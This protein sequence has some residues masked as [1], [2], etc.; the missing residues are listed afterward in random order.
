MRKVFPVTAVV[1]AGALTLSGCTAASAPSPS[2]SAAKPKMLTQLPAATSELDNVS[3]AYYAVLPTLDP[4]HSQSREA[5]LIIGNLCDTVL[6]AAPD[7]SVG[8]NLTKLKQVDDTHYVLT[9]VDG[10]KFWDGKPV[11]ASDVVYSLS[12]NLDPAVG[13]DFAPYFANV[14]S[15]TATNDTTVEITMKKP[16]I[17]LLKALGTMAGA[18]MEKAYSVAAGSKLGSLQGDLM[19][20]GPFNIASSDPSS[21][22]VLKRN[23]SYWNTKLRAHAKTVTINYLQDGSIASAAL[24]SGDVQGMY[25]FP[26]VTIDKLK[27]SGMGDAYAGLTNSVFSFVVGKLDGNPLDDVRLRQA[28]SLAIDR[29]AVAQRVFPNGGAP[30]TSFVGAAAA[31]QVKSTKALNVTAKLDE[32]K[33]LVEKVVKEKGEPRPISLLYTSGVGAEVGDMALYLQQ[34]AK[35]IGLTIK[36]DDKAPRDWVGAV[37]SATK[38]PTFDL[39]FNY[40]G[41]NMNDPYV[42]FANFLIPSST[43]NYSGYDHSS[44]TDLVAEGRATLD[45]GQRAEI[46]GK[47]EAR[48]LTDLPVIPVAYVPRQVFVNSKIG[49]VVLSDATF[50]GYP[51]AAALGGK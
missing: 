45:K 44:I 42:A 24:Q 10:A 49:G 50:M 3:W 39:T 1:I 19:C 18:V 15:I 9:L 20:S 37:M 4:A 41:L 8:D 5:G 30:A 35:K 43:A 27:S 29:T 46:A 21:K 38:N 12:R 40:A 34:V 31:E 11:T 23:D 22:I 13:S 2:S 47:I 16:D 6:Q 33:K 26:S 28:L 32:A 48:A 7:L 36:L 25:S 14:A 17:L 51:W